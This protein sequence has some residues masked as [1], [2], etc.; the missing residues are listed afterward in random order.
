MWWTLRLDRANSETQLGIRQSL[1]M[2]VRE[3]RL[4]A[5]LQ[6]QITP[7]LFRKVDCLLLTGD[8]WVEWEINP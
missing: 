4:I 6:E 1:G 7:T 2:L 5:I 8:R 3:V